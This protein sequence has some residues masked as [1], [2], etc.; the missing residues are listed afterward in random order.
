M[1][2]VSFEFVFFAKL[3]KAFIL[4]PSDLSSSFLSPL[5]TSSPPRRQDSRMSNK[6]KLTPATLDEKLAP[7]ALDSGRTGQM[8]LWKFAEGDVV[9]AAF[10]VLRFISICLGPRLDGW[11][12]EDVRVSNSHAL[13]LLKFINPALH[14]FITKYDH[15]KKVVSKVQES[16]QPVKFS[17]VDQSE[18]LSVGKLLSREIYKF[19]TDKEVSA[20]MYDDGEWWKSK[21]GTAL[22]ATLSAFC[23]KIK[24]AAPKADLVLVEAALGEEKW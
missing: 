10:T 15:T 17:D 24:A 16:G 13:T 3:R 6:V 11:T 2:S 21:V 20:M 8:G 22:K 7:N 4:W 18:G 19:K 12:N 5:R 23:L 14:A 9:I 1:F